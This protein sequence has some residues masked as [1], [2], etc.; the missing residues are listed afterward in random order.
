MGDGPIL[1]SE[2]LHFAASARS[3][4]LATIGGAGR[5]RLVPICFVA[6]A[7]RADASGPLVDLYSPLDDK[8]KRSDD[9]R[10]LARVR[11]LAA[12]PEATVLIA[13]WSEDWSRLGWLRLECRGQVLDP[14]GAD[15]REH[16]AAVRLLRDKYPQYATH[17]LEHRP[18]IRL[19]VTRKVAWGDAGLAEGEEPTGG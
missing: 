19:T 2:Q 6:T 4:T 16:A 14:D 8:P 15:L 9:P 7:D 10:A 3:G 1:T 18:M 11:D 12:I 17:R 5:P 13:R